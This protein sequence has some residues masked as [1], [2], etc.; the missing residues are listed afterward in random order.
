MF[1]IRRIE[2]S[3]KKGEENAVGKNSDET[4]RKEKL[5]LRRAG[6]SMPGESSE[7]PHM[8]RKWGKF[9]QEQPRGSI[10]KSK[11]RMRGTYFGGFSPRGES[12]ENHLP[13]PQGRQNVSPHLKTRSRTP[14]HEV[15]RR[16]RG[17]LHRRTGRLAVHRRSDEGVRGPG[18]DEKES[19]GGK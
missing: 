19:R 11:R 8:K 10:N 13:P 18:E 5:S 16:R 14:S 9:R 1:A 2:Y 7:A 17:P 4:E 12:G 15:R 6:G 3:S